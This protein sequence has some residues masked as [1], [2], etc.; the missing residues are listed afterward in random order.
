MSRERKNKGAK[1]EGRNVLERDKDLLRKWK[2]KKILEKKQIQVTLEQYGFDLC[3][4]TYMQ[5][6]LTQYY[7]IH[8]SLN[9]QLLTT[10]SE[11]AD[12]EEPWY[13]EPSMS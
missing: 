5:V 13:R 9:P 7:T 8:D 3:W 4:S 1:C 10:N 12:T 6:S 2:Q 11:T